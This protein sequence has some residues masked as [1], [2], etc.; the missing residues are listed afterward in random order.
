MTWQTLQEHEAHYL[1]RFQDDYRRKSLER[2]VQRFVAGRRVLELRC[3]TGNLAIDLTL[4]GHDVVALDALPQAVQQTN[5]AAR[6]RGIGRDLAR[7][8]HLERLS[9]VVAGARFDTVLCL[10][11]LIHVPDDRTTLRELADVT[12]PGGRLIINAPAHPSL[13]GKRDAVLGHLRRYTQRQFR[14]LI[15]EAGFTVTLLRPWNFLALPMYALMEGLLRWE[16]PEGLR[17]GQRGP[18]NR[19]TNRLLRWWYLAVEN[20]LWFPCGLTWFAVAQLPEGA[21]RR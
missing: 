5:A 2:L 4:R 14:A 16:V 13:H 10:D 3:L 15:E 6:A 21:A 8:W 11:T 20:R 12:A 9:D 7:P 19:V 17:H 1:D 18:V